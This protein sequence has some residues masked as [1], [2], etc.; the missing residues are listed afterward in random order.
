MLTPLVKKVTDANIADFTRADIVVFGT[1]KTGTSDLPPDYAECVRV[2]KGVTL[3]GRTAGLFSMGA[4]KAT[5]RLRKAL[6]DTEISTL[7]EDPLFS[8]PK[9]GGPAEIAAWVKKL[10][11]FHQE[12]KNAHA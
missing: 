10:V 4:E 5:G 7:E 2:F 3:A 11:A 9:S 8:E 6:K 1:Q 12:S